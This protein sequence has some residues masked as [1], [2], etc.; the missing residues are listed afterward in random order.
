MAYDDIIA[1]FLF[2]L[3]R[4]DFGIRASESLISERFKVREGFANDLIGRASKS[5]DSFTYSRKR[6]ETYRFNKASILSW[7][8]FFARFEDFKKLNFMDEFISHKTQRAKVPI[9][10]EIFGL[11]ENRASLRVSDVTSVVYRD[12]C[13]WNAYFLTG[14]RLP[15]SIPLQE[16][17]TINGT[18]RERDDS[19]LEYV[20]SQHLN[21]EGWGRTL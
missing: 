6:V 15:A 9:I 10:S 2:F 12:F 18:V 5:I 17:E 16:I 19:T 8:L 14:G 21:V 13:L 4:G 20:L 11:F 3:E 1:K 7:F